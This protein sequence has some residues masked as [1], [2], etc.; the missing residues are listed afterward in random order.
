[1]LAR[2][3]FGP[4]EKAYGYEPVEHPGYVVR[5]HGKGRTTMVPWTIGRSYRDL[6]LTVA[7]DAVH[8]IVQELLAGD[9]IVAA[10]LPE[11]VEITVHKTGARLVVHVVNMSG[12]RRSNFGPPVPV[13]GGGLHVRTA[14]SSPTAHALVNDAPCQTN[15]QDDWLSITLPEIDLFDVIV[16]DYPEKVTQ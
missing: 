6:G 13:R 8:E 12:A 5:A 10:D 14:G 2:A 11:H 9:E 4:P 15:R 3:S 16:V 1:M 7:R